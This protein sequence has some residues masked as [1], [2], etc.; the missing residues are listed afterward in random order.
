ML[1]ILEGFDLS[2]TSYAHADQFLD[3]TFAHFPQ[4]MFAGSIIS[5]TS[6]S[7]YVHNA[8]FD[9]IQ[10]LVI[11]QKRSG[12]VFIRDSIARKVGA[13]ALH[14]LEDFAGNAA[15][16]ELADLDPAATGTAALAELDHEHKT[17]GGSDGLPSSATDLPNGFLVAQGGSV[18]IFNCTFIDSKA[19]KGLIQATDDQDILID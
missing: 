16:L 19:A 18:E 13:T 11:S 6:N 14:H 4:A 5:L 17:A 9:N 12:S 3:C 15:A 10:T 8:L 7:I 1:Q 2:N